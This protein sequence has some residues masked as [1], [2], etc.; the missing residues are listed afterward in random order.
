MKKYISIFLLFISFQVHA[1]IVKIGD[2]VPDYTFEKVVNHSKSTLNLRETKGK[3]LIIEFWG[4]WCGPCIP[5]LEHLD[6]LQKKFKNDVAVVGI[7]DDTEERL[8]KFLL[9]R[10]VAIP[11][12]SDT[13]DKKSTFFK[14]EGV[15]ITYVVDRTNKILAITSPSEITEESLKKLIENKNVDFKYNTGKSFS[16]ADPF[17]VDLKTIYSFTIKPAID[18]IPGTI[19]KTHNQGVF[20]G[21]RLSFIN[22]TPKFFIE[23]IFQKT[24]YQTLVLADKSKFKFQPENIFSYDIIVPEDDKD[25]LYV[26]AQEE[27]KRRLNY[28]VYVEQRNTDVYILKNISEKNILKPSQLSPNMSFTY[29]KKPR[30][31]AEGSELSSL[32]EFLED[33]VR[34]VIIDETGLK[35]KYD[36]TID[37]QNKTELLEELKK[38]GLTLEKANRSVEMLIIA[39]K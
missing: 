38:V 14:I 21:R 20:N 24:S 29:G 36:Y 6:E 11:L 18:T 39:D 19:F 16:N 15:P 30:I 28:K 35:G 9:K 10:P 37:F 34:T 13:F 8:N 12:V 1:Q 17:G 7:S 2:S 32:R 31:S 5:A 3:I 23:K 27:I 4:T 33:Q 22:V 25:N 26:I